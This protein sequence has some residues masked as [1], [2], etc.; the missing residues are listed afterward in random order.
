MIEREALCAGSQCAH[1]IGRVVLVD[2][3]YAS[4]ARVVAGTLERVEDDFKDS[5]I[6][7]TLLVVGGTRIVIDWDELPPEEVSIQVV[8]E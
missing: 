2:I 4:D 8:A 7:R 1:L 6:V 5:S 3:E